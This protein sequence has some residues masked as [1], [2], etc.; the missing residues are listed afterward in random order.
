MRNPPTLHLGVVYQVQ[1]NYVYSSDAAPHVL[2][3]LLG[4]FAGCLT[5]RALVAFH[6]VGEPSTQSGL[7]PAVLAFTFYVLVQ[8][9]LFER[10]LHQHIKS[11]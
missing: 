2:P 8:F 1:S 10:K 5:A 6:H 9:A 11:S 7:A 4:I 3:V